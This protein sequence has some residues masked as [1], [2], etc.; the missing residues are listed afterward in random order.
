MGM[1]VYLGLTASEIIAMVREVAS[2]LGGTTPT[3]QQF[4]EHTKSLPT[5][6]FDPRNHFPNA[7]WNDIVHMAELPVKVH[8]NCTLECLKSML[9]K[10]TEEIGHVPTQK[11][12][13]SSKSLPTTPV[14]QHAFGSYNN[15]L[16]ACGLTPNFEP[17]KYTEHDLIGIL[18][19]FN[20]NHDRVPYS[21]E[22]KGR[23][24]GLK[25]FTTRF[26][27]WANALSAAGFPPNPQTFG[28]QYRSNHGHIRPSYI[29]GK[30][31]DMIGCYG[32]SH[33]HEVP[34]NLLVPTEFL[35][36]LDTLVENSWFIEVAGFITEGQ[37]NGTN[38]IKKSSVDYG[39]LMKLRAKYDVL[40]QTIDKA[41]IIIVFKDSDIMEKLSPILTSRGRLKLVDMVPGRVIQDRKFFHVAKKYTNETLLELIRERACELNRTPTLED[42]NQPGWPYKSIYTKR[43]R[44]S[45]WVEE[46]GLAQNVPHYTDDDLLSILHQMAQYL[47]RAPQPRDLNGNPCRK[48]Y[49]Q[50]FGSWQQ[51]LKRLGAFVECATVSTNSSVSPQQKSNGLPI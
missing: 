37:W 16:D 4:R 22:F 24:P 32:L 5:G 13:D 2:N 42:M 50:R 12:V 47:G 49:N 33:Q 45:K 48:T 29:D 19:Q 40:S 36:T 25:V 1:P 7:S 28:K 23:S 20:H 41:R 30:V 46:A 15:A 18:Q 51:V 31:D 3:F 43:K 26:G 17:L 11:E 14:Y 44:W 35:Y 9:L 6:G 10:F 38:K 27:S 21:E 34:Y 8:P 39:Y